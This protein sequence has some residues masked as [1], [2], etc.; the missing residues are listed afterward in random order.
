MPIC[1]KCNKRTFDGTRWNSQTKHQE[2]NGKYVCS[3]C[4]KEIA[5]LP[6][7]SGQKLQSNTGTSSGVLLKCKKIFGQFLL[8]EKPMVKVNGGKDEQLE[9]NKEFLISLQPDI[10]Y[11]I[12]VQFPY[13]GRLCGTASFDVKVT[14]GEIQKFEYTTPPLMTIGGTIERKR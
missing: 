11:T 13:L 3:A 7:E 9:W 2:L 14:N 4:Q 1:A 6:N 5:S 8:T 12:S 10:P